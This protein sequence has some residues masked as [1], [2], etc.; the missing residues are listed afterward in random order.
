M[1]EADDN[2]DNIEAVDDVCVRPGDDF[3]E[4]EEEEDEALDYN[5]SVYRNFI[6]SNRKGIGRDHVKP[7]PDL[8][9]AERPTQKLK[10]KEG[11]WEGEEEE[12]EVNKFASSRKIPITHQVDLPGHSKAVTS[13]SVEPAGNRVVTGSL[14]Y[15]LYMYDFGGMDQRHKYFKSVEA[16]DGYPVISL[17]HSPKGDK[18]V[19]GTGSS[20]PRVYTREGEKVISFCKGDMY[21][22]DLANIKGHIMEVTGVQWHPSLSLSL[23]TSSLDG[24]LRIWNLEGEALF[25][26]LK[27]EHVLK[28]KG[29]TGQ[30]RVGATSC[31]YSPD[32]TM[33]V[34][35]GADGSIQFWRVREKGREKKSLS[36]PDVIQRDAH[37]SLS[38]SLSSV[39]CVV[40]SESGKI[41]ASRGKDGSVRLWDFSPFLKPSLSRS[42]SLS[43][44]RVFSNL[45]NVYDTA[46]LDFSPDE[47]LVVCCTS[48]LSLSSS[49]RP[50]SSPLSPSFLC[51]LDVPTDLSPSLSKKEE[52]EKEATPCLQ[53]P[54]GEAK[55]ERESENERERERA[56][57]VGIAVV[58]QKKTNQIFVGTSGGF[59]RV[60]FSLSL[61]TK[62]AVLTA[63][64][65]PKKSSL[66]LSSSNS[67]G[68]IYNPHALPLFREEVPGMKRRSD[69]PDPRSLS[70]PEKPVAT[71]PGRGTNTSFFFTQY[72]MA[73]RKG[74]RERER[75]MDPREALLRM[76]EKAKQDPVFIGRAYKDTQPV[77]EMSE[78]SFEQEQEEFKKKQRLL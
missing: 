32:G 3:E 46:N 72:V 71:G 64:R 28:I 23:L 29:K 75:E 16:D 13:L 35:G 47:S 68:A 4:E 53:L 54:V 51:F 57:V 2:L 7:V 25:G 20:Q 30:M 70:L 22:R 65:A 21:L 50:S 6:S 15:M 31:C 52:R 40:V 9:Q 62:G 77:T 49:S 18:F 14:D 36:Q 44:L 26:N 37:P 48:P 76:D 1:K 38:L 41:L 34:G 33:V 61:S 43:L 45:P 5:S 55:R 39:T 19:V 24:S 73:G 67:V 74:E 42:L 78:Q 27:S 59:T 66:S 58:W 63:G 10:K 56:S 60:F 69:K 8:S 12:D 11:E 17:S